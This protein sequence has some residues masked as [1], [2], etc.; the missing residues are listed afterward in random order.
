MVHYSN[1]LVKLHTVTEYEG[2]GL[3]LAT[4]KKIIENIGGTLHVKSKLNHGSTFILS[5]PN[6]AI[7]E[8]VDNRVSV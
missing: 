1:P 5:F 8:P 4:C 3:G 6:S 2:S 7:K